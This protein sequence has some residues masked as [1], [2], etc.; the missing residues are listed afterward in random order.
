LVVKDSTFQ[1]DEIF[2]VFSKEDVLN[3]FARTMNPATS[4]AG[5]VPEDFNVAGQKTTL[6]YENKANSRKNIVEI[7]IRNDSDIHYRQVR[8]NMYSRD[9]LNILLNNLKQV[10]K[11]KHDKEIAYFGNF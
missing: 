3:T 4:K 11:G 2:K 6:W 5:N 7:E 8:F 9:A 1:K 10:S